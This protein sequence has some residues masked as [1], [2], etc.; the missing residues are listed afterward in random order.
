MIALLVKGFYLN[1][2]E[3]VKFILKENYAFCD[4]SDAKLEEYQSSTP[5][6]NLPVLKQQGVWSGFRTI[7][8]YEAACNLRIKILIKQQ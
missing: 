4:L 2:V 5:V 1:F 8:R 3:K 6:E 7:P